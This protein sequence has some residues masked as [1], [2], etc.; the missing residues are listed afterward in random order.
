MAFKMKGM[1]FYDSPMKK[2]SGDKVKMDAPV[3]SKRKD[4]K[5]FTPEMTEIKTNDEK[6]QA[7][8]IKWRQGGKK[9]DY[10]DRKDF[11]KMFTDI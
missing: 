3:D 5:Y 4:P 7:A 1:S 11:G 10:P 8:V 9:G 2:K 6:H